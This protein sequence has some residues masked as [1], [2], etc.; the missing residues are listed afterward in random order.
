MKDTNGIW[1]KSKHD[2]TTHFK[3]SDDL[4][5]WLSLYSAVSSLSYN[6]SIKYVRFTHSKHS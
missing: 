1:L 5:C 4:L 2:G 3:V 6:V